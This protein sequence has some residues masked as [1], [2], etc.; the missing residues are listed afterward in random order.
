MRWR[1]GRTRSCPLMAGAADLGTPAHQLPRRPQAGI[2][3]RPLLRAERINAA[4]T[5]APFE[6]L[7][8][9]NPDKRWIH[10]ITAHARTHHARRVN[11]WLERPGCRI[12]LQQ[13][14]FWHKSSADLV[15]R[16]RCPHPPRAGGPWIPFVFLKNGVKGLAPCGLGRRPILLS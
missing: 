16:G 11:A 15:F 9:D 8:A 4:S 2:R 7:E 13:F 10:V 1:G 5:L 12:K 6:K 3:P 14:S